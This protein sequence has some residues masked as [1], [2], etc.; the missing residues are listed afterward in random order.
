M[1]EKWLLR[2]FNFVQYSRDKIP[3]NK[4]IVVVQKGAFCLVIYLEEMK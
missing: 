1:D 3:M 2:F 4:I